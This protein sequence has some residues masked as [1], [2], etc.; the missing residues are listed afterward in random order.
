M[1]TTR[2]PFA[3]RIYTVAA[4]FGIAVLAPMYFLEER[5][6]LDFPPAITHPE[7]FYGFVGLALVWQ[8]AF[9]VIARDPVRFRP[10][11]PITLLEKLSFGAPVVI[12]YLLGRVPLPVLAMGLIDLSLGVAFLMAF[13]RTPKA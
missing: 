10:L 3:T 2:A 12:L 13:L 4:I 1:S 6:G 11:M 9:L 8:F 7:H 5:I